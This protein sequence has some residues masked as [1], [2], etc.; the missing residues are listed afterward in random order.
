MMNKI[1]KLGVIQRV[2][3]KPYLIQLKKK[4]R[5]I[6]ALKNTKLHKWGFLQLSCNGKVINCTSFVSPSQH[7]ILSFSGR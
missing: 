2:I 6:K 5:Y 4:K 7:T 1:S 3:V